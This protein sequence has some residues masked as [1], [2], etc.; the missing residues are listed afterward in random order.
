MEY[1]V[2]TLSFLSFLSFFCPELE[3]ETEVVV[4]REKK[5]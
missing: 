2:S 1:F 4:E 3:E 5:Q